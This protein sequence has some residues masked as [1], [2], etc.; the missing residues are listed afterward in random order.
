MQY[1]N[2]TGL[3]HAL[4]HSSGNGNGS[5]KTGTFKTKTSGRYQYLADGYIEMDWS[6]DGK[7]Y[8]NPILFS[9]SPAV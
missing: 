8:R 7:D 5:Y 9:A 3:E 6:G 2:Y 4:E 1:A